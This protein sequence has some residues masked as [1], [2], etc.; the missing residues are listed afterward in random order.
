M[1]S[2]SIPSTLQKEKDQ[3][4]DK[5]KVIS[6]DNIIARTIWGLTTR[7]SIHEINMI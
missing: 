1:V 7:K 2:D 4:G 3:V 5:L 6:C